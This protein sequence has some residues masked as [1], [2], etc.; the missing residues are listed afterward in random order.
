MS[1][2]TCHAC[3]KGPSFGPAVMVE[4][5]VKQSD[6]HLL[7]GPWCEKISSPAISRVMNNSGLSITG[8]DFRQPLC[9]YR[10]KGGEE[11]NPEAHK[12]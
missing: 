10:E 6:K 4:L 7:T 3:V 5:P 2:D 11:K 12:S 9:V 1:T 8:R